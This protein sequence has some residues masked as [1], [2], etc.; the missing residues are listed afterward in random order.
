MRFNIFDHYGVY[1][2]NVKN[3]K[4]HH[5]MAFLFLLNRLIL[6][7]VHDKCASHRSIMYWE[8]QGMQHAS[9]ICYSDNE[10]PPRHS[11]YCE[12]LFK[13]NGRREMSPNHV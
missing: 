4:S 9:F 2:C 13:N 3:V 7:D 6:V 5:W 12:K 1:D 11:K 10:Y 8:F